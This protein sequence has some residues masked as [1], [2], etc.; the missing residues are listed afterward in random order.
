[1]ITKVVC[2]MHGVSYPEEGRH[3]SSEDSEAY[4]RATSPRGRLGAAHAVVV[5]VVEVVDV[6]SRS[7][8]SSSS[9]ISLWPCY[10]SQ[11]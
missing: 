6:S 2:C 9:I 4:C 5:E 10:Q 8:S 3:E 11:R 7:S 1:M